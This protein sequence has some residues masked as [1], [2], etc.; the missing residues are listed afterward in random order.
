MNRALMHVCFMPLHLHMKR[1]G[2]LDEEHEMRMEELDY[3]VG[4]LGHSKLSK[5]CHS[6]RTFEVETFTS[7][8]PHFNNCTI[9]AQRPKQPL[10]HNISEHG[11]SF[12]AITVIIQLGINEGD[13]L[14]LVV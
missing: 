14:L 3:G 2:A 4:I 10:Q 1:E 11:Q 8:R 13:K 6:S 5:A 7:C 12:R 9:P